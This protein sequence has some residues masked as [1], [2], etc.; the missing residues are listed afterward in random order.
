MLVFLG[1]VGLSMVIAYGIMATHG[2]AQ[3]S[4]EVSDGYDPKAH[5]EHHG[6]EGSLNSG[7]S[8]SEP[9][10]SSAA[11]TP[12]TERAHNL[13]DIDARLQLH[14]DGLNIFENAKYPYTF[15]A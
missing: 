10:I 13:D 4:K 11:V 15:T 3:L 7:T 8:V 6:I 12:T 1:M 5:H 9:D 14:R 2:K